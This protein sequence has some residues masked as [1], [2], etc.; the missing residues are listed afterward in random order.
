MDLNISIF[1]IIGY[2]GSLLVVISMLMTSVMKLRIINTAG[3]VLA[4]IYAIAIKAYP[5]LV[6]N[7]ALIIINII[8]MR[9][10]S[11]NSTEYRLIKAPGNDT[12][13]NDLISKYREDIQ[14]FFPSYRELTVEDTAFIILNSD[15]PVGITAGRI[16]DG[17]YDLYY[18]YT[19]PA[20]RDCSVG[21]YL[22][23]HIKGFNINVAQISNPSKDHI[24]YLNKVGFSKNDDKYIK[25]I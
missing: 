16:N 24:P 14:S 13:L 4:V 3:S 7:V 9:K 21:Q 10:L 2:A 20:Y 12:V 18:D 5:T 23:S 6:M 15:V 1:D 22:F 19:I 17:C 25:I 8:N 11:N